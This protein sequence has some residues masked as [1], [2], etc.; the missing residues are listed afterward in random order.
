MIQ[1]LLGWATESWTEVESR[2]IM[3]GLTARPGGPATVL[4]LDGRHFVAFLEGI[5]RENEGR[6]TAL[7]E[8]YTKHRPVKHVPVDSAARHREIDRLTRL[9]GG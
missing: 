5:L 4:D 9:F 1:E 7:D 8:L 2:A 3:V 6:T